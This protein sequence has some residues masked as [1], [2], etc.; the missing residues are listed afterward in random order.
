MIYPKLAPSASPWATRKPKAW[1]S[2]SPAAE[3]SMAAATWISTALSHV[4]LEVYYSIKPKFALQ[5]KT[6]TWIIPYFGCDGAYL[7]L[8]KRTE[9]KI[10][11]GEA[12]NFSSDNPNDVL[13]VVK[14][15]LKIMGKES[16]NPK[17]MFKIDNE[18]PSHFPTAPKREKLSAGS[19]YWNLT[20]ESI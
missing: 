18:I 17:I 3:I 10:Y 11:S 6:R 19:R 14:S 2:Q 15:I 4:R 20:S 12:Y 13:E 8:A 9:G 16:L 1:T 7:T 5:W